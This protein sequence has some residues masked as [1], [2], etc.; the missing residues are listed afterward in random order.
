MPPR[1][2]EDYSSAESVRLAVTALEAG[3]LVVIPTDTVLGLAA[4]P[5]VPGAKQKLYEAKDRD[6]SKP[7][8]VLVS[9]AGNAVKRGAVMGEAAQKLARKFWPGPLTMVLPTGGGFEGFRVPDHPAALAV[10]R[11]V[12]GAIYATSANR[13]GM[14][15][16]GSAAEACR[17]L[18]PCVTMAVT[19]GPAPRGTE[20]TV[21]KVE[22]GNV[23]ILREGA[24][25]EKDIL[26]C[27]KE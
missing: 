12:G 17:M 6:S 23:T 16:A 3:E 5:R 22:G 20:S 18:G 26:A 10:I 21:V 15:P 11:A 24:V 13:S 8:P 9:D 4:D 7:I 27:L 14:K 19:V 25:P 2:E 1:T